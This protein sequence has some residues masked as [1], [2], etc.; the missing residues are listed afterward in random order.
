MPE[1]LPRTALNAML[2]PSRP[3]AIRHP[4][5]NARV[6]TFAAAALWV[7]GVGCD[8]SP[9]ETPAV[10]SPAASPVAATAQHENP[11]SPA[12]PASPSSSAHVAG[13]RCAEPEHDFG[14][15]PEGDICE[16]RFVLANDGAAPVVIESVTTQCGCTVASLI[17]ADGEKVVP[18]GNGVKALGGLLTLEPGAKCSAVVSFNSRNQPAGVAHKSTTIQSTDAARPSLQ[19]MIR[20]EVQR[21]FTLEPN[22]LQFGELRRGESKT[23]RVSV[24]SNTISAFTITGLE[25]APPWV[26]WYAEPIPGGAAVDVTVGESAPCGLQQQNLVLLTSDAKFRSVALPLF[27][28]IRA[29]VRF[30][31]GNPENRERIDF[32]LIDPAVKSA[33]TIDVVNEDPRVP[34]HVLS[35]DIDSPQ[36]GQFAARVETVKEGEHYR[37]VFESTPTG[38]NRTLR[39]LLRIAT[40]HPDLPRRDLPFQAWVRS[41]P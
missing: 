12:S 16:H 13:L 23:L 28:T 26:R 40:D 32:G 2:R 33:R 27:A 39:G 19:L 30:D 1:L 8:R 31:T 17:R 4:I 21:A 5:S 6:A 15:V 18:P 11:A 22:S 29:R 38:A 3:S 34:L 36:A 10:V 35:A 7:V 14:P 9:A 25:G 20:A 37:V 24:R 41:S